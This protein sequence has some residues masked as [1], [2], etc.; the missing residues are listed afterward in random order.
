MRDGA[1]KR[2]LLSALFSAVALPLVA[3]LLLKWV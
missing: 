2:V 1:L 3:G